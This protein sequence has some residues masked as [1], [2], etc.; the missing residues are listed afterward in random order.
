MPYDS[1]LNKELF[2]KYW[3]YERGKIIVSVHS[4]K[5]GPKKLQ[6]SREVKARGGRPTFARLGRLSKEEIQGVLPLIQEALKIM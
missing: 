3:E 2:S 4:Y 1:N 6:I 5:N